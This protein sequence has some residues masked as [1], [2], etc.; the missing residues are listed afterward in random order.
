MANILTDNVQIETILRKISTQ[1]ENAGGFI[2]PHIDLVYDGHRLSIQKSGNSTDLHCIKVPDEMLVRYHDFD[3]DIEDKNIVIAPYKSNTSSPQYEL[4]THILALYNESGIFKN[5]FKTSPWL[6]YAQA[7]ELMKLLL[8]S[9]GGPNVDTISQMIGH[10]EYKDEL[11]LFTFFK[12]R[13]TFCRL[14]K[15]SDEMTEVF[16]P[17]IEFLSHHPLGAVY[18]RL[19]DKETA[20]SF[21]AVHP[22][23]PVQGSA[24]CFTCFG[25]L[26]AMDAYMHYG[27][28]DGAAPFVRSIPLTIKL[29]DIGTINIRTRNKSLPL[30]ERPEHLRDLG[31]YLPIINHR[32]GS[33]QLGL[34]HI[35][36]PNA[37]A[38][39]S[40]RRILHEAIIQLEPSLDEKS[41]EPF[42]EE[43]E[44]IIVDRNLEYY[45]TIEALMPAPTGQ[46]QS[47]RAVF[48]DDIAGVAAQQTQIIELYNALHGK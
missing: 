1:I 12:K 39:F 43:L 22:A 36:I 19:H 6:N 35:I 16:L 28:V 31:H 48:Y 8:K 24:E 20:Q 41:S 27:A 7:P 5:H 45:R 26:D 9:R 3:V 42:V 32:E 11:A 47:P 4:F 17:L 15:Q 25:A 30:D 13:M 21:M 38:P 10:D 37:Q 23:T 2:D 18:E 40:L 34:S 44:T 14:N 33:K 46:G 29:P